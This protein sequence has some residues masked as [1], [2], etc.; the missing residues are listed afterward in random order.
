MK[1][2]KILVAFLLCLVLTVPTVLSA[3]ALKP[4]PLPLLDGAGMLSASEEEDLANKIADFE[5][6]WGMDLLIVTI[7][8][9]GYKNMSEYARDIYDGGPDGIILLVKYVEDGD[10]NEFFIA[11]FGEGEYAVNSYGVRYIEDKIQPNLADGEFFDAFDEFI[12]LADDFAREAS[13]GEPYSSSNK[14]ITL[15]NIV[16]T[17]GIVLAV[18]VAAGLITVSVM[19]YKMNNAR[20]QKLA[21]EYIKSGSF[22]LKL[23]R[24][25]YLYSN[26][27]RTLRSNSSS[28]GGGS[29]SRGSGGG[30]RF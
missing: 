27:T 5:E 26:T 15:G 9:L 29:R 24:D 3:F 30:R 13:E 23:S 7:T 14:R 28:S 17:F 19:K 8:N 11:A 2:S 20:P 16:L 4:L 22:N 10:D 25:L 6:K 21:H 12:Y 18:S 1:I